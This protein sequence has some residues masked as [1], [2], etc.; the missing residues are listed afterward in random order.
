VCKLCVHEIISENIHNHEIYII[1]TKN[2][3]YTIP[4]CSFFTG[5][6]SRAGCYPRKFSFSKDNFVV[7]L[8]QEINGHY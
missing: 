5:V 2:S 8:V 1:I 7:G 4:Y 3:G 6:I